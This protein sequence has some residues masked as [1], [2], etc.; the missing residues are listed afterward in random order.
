[1]SIAA[2]AALRLR[3]GELMTML[4]LAPLVDGLFAFDPTAAS[5]QSL[6]P[7]LVDLGLLKLTV[8]QGHSTAIA[9]FSSSWSHWSFHSLFDTSHWTVLAQQFETDVFADTRAWWSDFVASGKI[10]T[11][12]FGIVLGYLMR[13]LTSYG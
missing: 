10:W 3:V 9:D 5:L 4:L 6:V 2:V 12:L 13:A 1:M 11:L 8:I 7:G